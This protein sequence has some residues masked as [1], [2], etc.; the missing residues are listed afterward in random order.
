M[1]VLFMH[2][3]EFRS[4]VSYMTVDD[5]LEASDLLSGLKDLLQDAGLMEEVG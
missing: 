4:D 5:A 3:K 2:L 1:S